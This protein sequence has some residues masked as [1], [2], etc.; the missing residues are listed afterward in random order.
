[1]SIHLCGALFLAIGY[2]VP[3]KEKIEKN[4]NFDDLYI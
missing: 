2:F 3:S 1:M 4:T